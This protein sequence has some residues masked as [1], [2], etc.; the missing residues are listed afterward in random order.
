MARSRFDILSKGRTKKRGEMNSNE[1][2]FADFLD[3]DTDVARWWFEPFSLRL[4]A[5][6]NGGQP[7]RFTPDFLVLRRNGE[8][9]VF[10]VKSGSGYDDTA[11]G[12]RIKC[13]AEQYPLWVFAKANRI[14]IKQGGGW[15]IDTV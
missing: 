1:R 13:A 7:A 12:V 10:D 14:P 4:S 8:T 11:A 3:A 2:K 5:P 6:E 9:W 15:K